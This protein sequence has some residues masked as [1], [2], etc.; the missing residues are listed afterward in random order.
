MNS[1]RFA[2][3]AGIAYLFAGLLALVPAT[4]SPPPAGAPGISFALLYGY[5]LGLFPVNALH[6]ALN[7]VVGVWGVAAASREARALT[8]ARALTVLF[9]VLAVIG[10]FPAGRTLAGLMPIHGA[11]VWLHAATAAAAFY[12]GWRAGATGKE[13][14][15]APERRRQAIPVARERRFGL[16]DRREG[17]AM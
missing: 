14:R 5:F 13:R 11:D 9:G 3:I 10:L 2:L 15:R 17:F 1:T 7:I 8:Y 6:S 12:F 4:L 16:A